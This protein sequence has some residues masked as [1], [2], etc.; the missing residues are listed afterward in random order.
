ML[1]KLFSDAVRADGFHSW[2]VSN[3]LT[4]AQTFPVS[5]ARIPV[6]GLSSH[7]RLDIPSELLQWSSAVIVHSIYMSLYPALTTRSD[8]FL[9]PSSGGSLSRA[10]GLS[11][12]TLQPRTEGRYWKRN[13]C[14]VMDAVWGGNN[15]ECPHPRPLEH[16]PAILKELFYTL[17]CPQNNTHRLPAGDREFLCPQVVLQR[18]RLYP[19]A[20]RH[21]FGDF[22]ETC[23]E[24]Y[25]CS[26]LNGWGVQPSMN[27]ETERLNNEWIM[28][29]MNNETER[30]RKE[31]QVISRKL[32]QGAE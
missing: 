26:L 19:P 14:L 29:L 23:Y 32:P 18:C 6:L 16:Y 17:K 5:K 20:Q 11:L 4:F 25:I 2:T 24:L 8:T 28:K 10:S 12:V 30:L 7:V 31:Y 22:R 21:C 3:Q 9:N 27:N 15:W 13:K 1:Y